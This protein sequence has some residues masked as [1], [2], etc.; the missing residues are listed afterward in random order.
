MGQFRRAL[1]RRLV[2]GGPS[3]GEAVTWDCRCEPR[4]PNPRSRRALEERRSGG[5]EPAGGRVP[6]RGPPQVPVPALSAP[7]LPHYLPSGRFLASDLTYPASLQGGASSPLP[8]TGLAGG[9]VQRPGRAASRGQPVPSSGPDSHSGVSQ[10]RETS[11]PSLHPPSPPPAHRRPLGTLRPCLAPCTPPPATAPLP[12]PRHSPCPRRPCG[13][14]SQGEAGSVRP[15][16][17]LFQPLVT[18]FHSQGGPG[19]PDPKHRTG[20]LR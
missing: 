8:T 6:A 2:S 4:A 9:F 5:P 3:Q 11:R 13:P 20:P 16:L 14:H 15:Q 19:S 18:V 10:S 12:V 17:D 1:R 7:P